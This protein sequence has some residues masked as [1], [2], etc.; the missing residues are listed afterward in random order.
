MPMT[1]HSDRHNPT[2]NRMP[3]NRCLVVTC[4]NKYRTT[5]L[6]LSD[7]HIVHFDVKNLRAVH[8][9]ELLPW[10]PCNHN[11]AYYSRKMKICSINFEAY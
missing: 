3:V 11:H 4:G 6:I 1:A 2:F 10:V 5:I 7:V 8:S 9:C